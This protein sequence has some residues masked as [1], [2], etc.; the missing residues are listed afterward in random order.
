MESADPLQ[1]VIMGV[2]GS[3]KTTVATLLAQRRGC[4][5]AEAD[6]FHSEASIAKL[7]SGQPLDDADRWPWLHRLAGWMRERALEGH[8]SVVTCSA[9]KRAYRDVLRTGSTNV[10]FIHLDGPPDL[11]LERLSG[12]PGHFVLPGLLESQLAILEPLEP[13]E[14]GA[15]LDVSKPLEALVSSVLACLERMP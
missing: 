11:L 3:G 8:S 14:R 6:D 1:I 2:C 13:D 12:R 9:L 7:A 5:L 10:V 15:K 4:T